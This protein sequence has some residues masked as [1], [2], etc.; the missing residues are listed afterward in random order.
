MINIILLLATLS[1]VKKN[2]DN[3]T[4][5]RAKPRD[6]NSQDGEKTLLKEVKE[7]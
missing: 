6:K 2:N 5:Y 4:Q 1:K 7:H 3:L